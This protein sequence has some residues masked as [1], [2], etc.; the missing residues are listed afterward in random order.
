[1]KYLTDQFQLCF[2]FGIGNTKL[3]HI[4]MHWQHNWH[5]YSRKLASCCICFVLSLNFGVKRNFWPAKFL[6]SRHMCIHRVI[7]YIC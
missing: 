7:I 3:L 2:Y 5:P 6:T 1:M 4:F